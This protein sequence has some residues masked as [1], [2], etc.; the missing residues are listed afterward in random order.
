MIDLMLKL[1]MALGMV[2]IEYE[3]RYIPGKN[4]YVLRI[5]GTEAIIRSAKEDSND[6]T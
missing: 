4:V 3:I 1:E 6:Q 2:G 5:D